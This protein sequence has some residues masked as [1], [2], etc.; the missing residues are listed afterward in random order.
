MITSANA[1]QVIQRIDTIP[2]FLHAYAYHL[3]MRCGRI[4]PIQLLDIAHRQQLHGVKIHVLDGEE[5]ALRHASP[6]QLHDFAARATELGL[7]LHIETSSS[8]AEAIDEAVYIAVH[9]GAT[10]VRFY[11]RYEGHLSEVLYRV[12][13]DIQY[14]K[15]RYSSS[16]LR[17]TIEQHE[18]LTSHEL[19][20]LVAESAWPQLSI[21]FDFANMINAN[22]APLPAL[23][24]MAAYVTEVHIKDARIVAEAGGFGHLACRSGQGDLPFRALLTC[25]LC[26][27]EHTPQVR[28]YG[29]EEEVDYYAPPFRFDGEGADPWIPWREMS[30]TPLPTEDL[31]AR[32]AQEI[33]DATAQL[34]FVRQTLSS[35][36]AEAVTLLG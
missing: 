4:L 18:D 25:L 20:S 15:T 2:L 34:T 11:P 19:V 35:I 12:A 29:L 7:E 31:P 14:M 8:S 30:E 9:T 17:F 36:R 22:E 33:T 21:L 6:E 26:L 1:A 28:A 13:A 3:N 23:E 10:S 24:A 16:G 27:G 32:L 5:T